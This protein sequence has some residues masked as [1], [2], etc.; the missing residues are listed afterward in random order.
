M[1]NEQEADEI[2]SRIRAQ[3]A[4]MPPAQFVLDLMENGVPTCKGTPTARLTAREARLLLILCHMARFVG[5]HTLAVPR[6]DVRVSDTG[7]Y[8]L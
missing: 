2:A 6:S 7:L 5:I 3:L 1:I 8:L 4:D